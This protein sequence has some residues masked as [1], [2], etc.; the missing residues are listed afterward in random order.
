MNVHTSNSQLRLSAALGRTLLEKPAPPLARETVVTLSTGMGRWLSMELASSLGVFAGV[1]FRFPNDTI[2]SCFRSVIPRIPSVSPFA[3]DTM[4]WRIASLLPTFREDAGFSVIT[5]YLGDAGDDRRLLQLSLTL[6][7]TFDQYTIYRPQMILDWDKGKDDSWQAILW[8]AL[9][10]GSTGLH[11]AALLQSFRQALELA[12][13]ALD[14]LPPRISLF[15]ISFLPP[16]HLEVFSLLSRFIEI[17]IY[18]LNPCGSYWGDLF[19]EKRKVSLT[20]NPDISE[21]TLEFYE[22]GNP[23]LSSLGTQG[24]EFFNLL[25]DYDVSWIDLDTDRRSVNHTLLGTIQNDILELYNRGND[26]S[27]AAV[28]DRDCSL[29]IHSCHG[30]LREM[31]VLY[32]N[33]L[34]M[35]DEVPELEPRDIVVMT[36]DMETYAPY[37]S[38]VFGN[39]SGGRAG[40]PFT[41][42]DQSARMKNPLIG[43]FKRILGLSTSRFGLNG[44]LEIL[45]TPQVMARFDISSEELQRIR[46]WLRD[47]GVRWG[48]DGH[49]RSELGFPSYSD[50][51]WQAGLDRLFLGYALAPAG[52]QHFSGAM[53]YDNIEGRQALPLG[54]LAHFI[55]MVTRVKI[56]LSN[57]QTLHEWADTL[58]FVADGMLQPLDGNDTG[59]SSLYSTFQV[60]R[61]TQNL[62]GFVHPIGIEAVNDHLMG[63]LEKSGGAS[64][65]LNGRVTFCA[66]LPMRSIPQRVVCLVGMNDTLFPRNPRQPAF[67]LMNGNRRRGDRSVRDE[68]RYLFLEAIISASERLYISYCG[69]NDRDNSILPPSVV[70]AE[71]LDYVHRGFC[72]QGTTDTPPDIVTRHRL[73]SFSTHYFSGST[74]S[75][76]FSYSTK[77]RDALEQRRLSGTSRRNFIDAPLE[78][79]PHQGQQLDIQQLV[80]FLSNPAGT[81][82]TARMNVRPFNPADEIDER[83]PFALNNL[84]GYALKQNLVESALNHQTPNSLYTAARAR[85]LLPPLQAGQIAFNA[86]WQES[87]DFARRVMPH[88]EK[89][90]EPLHLSL[91][92]SGTHFT[93]VMTG[94]Q[95]GTH[96]RWRSAGMK[97]RDRLMLWVEHLILNT[98]QPD[99]YPRESLLICND[100]CIRL[101]SMEN[102]AEVLVD[103]CALYRE[104]LNRPLHFFP[105]TSWMYLDKNM[106]AAEG[107]WLGTDHSPSPAESTQPAFSLCFNGH[108]V[109]D[110]E[111][112]NLAERVY[113]PLREISVEEK[114]K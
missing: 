37:I 16:F 80:R 2:D 24:Q 52:A 17:D 9:T 47:S 106:D 18:L 73:Q 45:E 53:P 109:L 11:R 25:L 62:S 93:G 21:E 23:L 30:P 112:I 10:D 74:E 13:P 104:G 29:Q 55:D 108:D 32:D 70:V 91:E 41:I 89:P 75:R 46:I 81:F 50:F 60:L 77:I 54:K 96:I 78:E 34:S 12:N 87:S 33:L 72:R 64:G 22:T 19:S 57:K 113:G 59:C 101:P 39:R 5:S 38:A 7:D 94:L 42:A 8:R 58:T 15:G 100:V 69:Q 71:L 51:S 86:L 44:M 31:E 98:L 1:D 102:A 85:T 99:G 63:L 49:H 90:L 84:S 43:S 103:L 66:M 114:L 79:I 20:L 88:L 14:L 61:D 95:E 105:Q 56:R 83:E 68:D 3:R 48:L 92:I 26:V 40:I 27:R 65:F 35:F 97:G 76:L 111:F 67:N 4:T 110:A 36:P 6:A 107:R 82:L 28:H